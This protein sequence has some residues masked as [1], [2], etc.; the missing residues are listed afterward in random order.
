MVLRPWYL[1]FLRRNPPKHPPA[2][3][4]L[5]I[6]TAIRRIGNVASADPL[7]RIHL[8]VYIRSILRRGIKHKSRYGLLAIDPYLLALE[9]VVERFVIL[10]Q[11]NNEKGVIIAESRNNQLDNELQLAF[12]R[13]KINGTRFLKPK[14]VAESIDSFI[15]KKKEDNIAGLQ[16]TD[17]FVTPIG[18]RYLN[19][20]NYY[21]N[22]DKIKN[23]FRKIKCGRYRGYGLVILPK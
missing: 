3:N 14:Q 2:L 16:L 17:T 23:K 8:R 18:R 21:L 9:V 22:Y 5:S 11:E 12:L 10:L 20:V 15:F 19:K 4:T 1:H 6:D 7:L 13:L